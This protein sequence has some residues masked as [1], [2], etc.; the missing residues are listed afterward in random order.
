MSSSFR[1]VSLI[2]TT[3]TV[4]L[5]RFHLHAVIFS[6][7]L[8]RTLDWSS[9]PHEPPPVCVTHLHNRSGQPSG[10]QV[11]DSSKVI[12]ARLGFSGNVAIMQQEDKMIPALILQPPDCWVKPFRG[13]DTVSVC[14]RA[15]HD[16]W[17]IRTSIQTLWHADPSNNRAIKYML[18]VTRA[19][20]GNSVTRHTA[21]LL[22]SVAFQTRR[23]TTSL[24]LF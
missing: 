22:M 5:T 14:R 19:D 12:M 4:A 24:R 9:P 18:V 17:R 15:S 2:N 7:F 23:G 10:L 20:D 8:L 1:G 6:T 21:P 11:F 16:Q 13:E 3:L